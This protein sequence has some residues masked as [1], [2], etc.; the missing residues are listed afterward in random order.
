NLFFKVKKTWYE[1]YHIDQSIQITRENIDI[2]ETFE[3]LA[4]SRYETAQASQ[5]DILRVQIEKEDLVTRVA[6]LQD[7]KNTL[8]QRLAEL[9]NRPESLQPDIPDTLAAQ[10]LPLLVPELKQKTLQQNPRL[11]KLDFE[12]A[13]ARS[14][15]DVARKEGLPK[16]GL[17]AD[18][19]FTGERDVTLAGNGKDAIVA[20]VGIQI[21]LYRKKYRAQKKQAQLR[22]QAVQNRQEATQNQLL[23]TFEET[24]RDFYNA[25]RRVSLYKDIQIQRTRQALDILTEEY[26][27]AAADFE[28]LLR[29]QRKLLEFQLAREEAIVDQNTAVAFTEYLYGKYNM[30]PDEIKI[31]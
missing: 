21:P 16:F 9:L 17:G 31:H 20:R 2:L 22:L 10:E 6:L 3:S 12:A 1:L 18:Y 19:I 26:A 23:T 13:S 4:T 7:T 30:N 24:L 8:Q 14:A 27:T 29:L 5:V 28:E 15:I 11:T 25:R